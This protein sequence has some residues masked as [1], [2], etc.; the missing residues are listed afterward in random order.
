MTSSYS[1]NYPNPL[2]IPLEYYY[3][4]PNIQYQLLNHKGDQLPSSWINKIN[5]TTVKISPPLK[6][7]IVFFHTDIIPDL[8]HEFVIYYYQDNS[9]N[10]HVAECIHQWA[11]ADMNC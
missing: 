5:R 7:D 10:T 1:V 6:E 9:N 11:R 4:G 2:E 8:G 3:R